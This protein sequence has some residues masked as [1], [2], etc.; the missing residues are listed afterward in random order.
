MTLKM[1]Y[2]PDI[3][4]LRAIAVLAV[5]FYHAE[6]E[7][8]SGGYVGVDVFFVIS[9]YLITTKIMQEIRA[10]RFS[11]LTFYEQRIRRI[12]PALFTVIIF[13]LLVGA[14]L[15][16]SSSYKNL[17]ESAVATTLSLANVLFLSQTGYFDTP[18]T[19]KPFLHTWSLSIEEQFYL[20]LPLLLVFLMRF[21]KR[22]IFAI[23]TF[24]G[25]IS[26]GFSTYILRDNP[27]ASFF[28]L[29]YRAWELL[30]GSLLALKSF[31]IKPFLHQFLSLSG[32]A[33]IFFS[34]II[35]SE[36]TLFPGIA[37]G[38]PVIGAALI[39][40]SGIDGK[41]FVSKLLSTRPFVFIGKISYSL[42]LWHWPF[43]V[44]GKYYLIRDINVV[45]IIIWLLLTFLISTL[46][47]KFIETPFRVKSFL[48][49][50]RIFVFAGS[51]IA[52]ALAFGFSVY[53]GDGLPSRFL[54]NKMSMPSRS[55]WDS[56]YNNWQACFAG[57]GDDFDFSKI[58]ELCS[59]GASHKNPPS[60]ILWGDS[61]AEALASSVDLSA[62][63]AGITGYLISGSG[64][65][66][67]GD[68][69]VSALPYC[70]EYNIKVIDYIKAHPEIKTI[71][72]T[73]RWA[74]YADGSRYKAEEGVSSTL[75]DMRSDA[76][77]INTN[78]SLFKVGVQRMIATLSTLKRDIVIVSSVPEVGYQ[79]P[80][81]HFIAL[82]TGR[83]INEII[84]PTMEEYLIRNEK[85]IP[86]FET[87][88]N[89]AANV[90]LVSPSKLLC[91]KEICKVIEKSTPLY[92]DDDH[93]S[94]FGAHYISGL[95]DG[96]FETIASEEKIGSMQ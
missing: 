9:G 79:V 51:T 48:E 27:N 71:I 81:S 40:Y 96:I 60:F 92:R 22:K 39:I 94:T 4:G 88:Q 5:L 29:Q 19:L 65:P 36:E 7:M 43:I 53:L 85:V 90:E 89:D 56:E 83:N 38:A 57:D 47:W 82:R 50:P 76:D 75:L 17:G 21:A 84:A 6:I 32:I 87:A 14:W 28:L 13:S 67:L 1:K 95:F 46:S 30:I 70:H 59:L 26:L 63:R 77:E 58:A 64:C 68:I 16:D 33:M 74:M 34:I 20:F 42:Y 8:F 3:D 15:F 23:L 78:A 54:E 11:L 52:F 18:S 62:S 44:F 66:P 55:E 91:N 41:P 31:K 35:Y 73:G 61:H 86:V 45:D 12:I 37:A 10:D 2:R 24:L 25:L 80:S 69:N 93:L 72:I 49:R